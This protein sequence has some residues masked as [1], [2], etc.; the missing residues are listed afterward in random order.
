MLNMQGVLVTK[1]EKQI[2]RPNLGA[3]FFEPKIHFPPVFDVKFGHVCAQ[4]AGRCHI[5][6]YIHIYIDMCL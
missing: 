4:I 6:I 1:Q 3:L 5:Y 2:V